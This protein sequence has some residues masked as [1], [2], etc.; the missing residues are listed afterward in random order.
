MVRGRT[1]GSA[2][3]RGLAVHALLARS[4]TRRPVESERHRARPV[5]AHDAPMM[6]LSAR[7]AMCFSAHRPWLTRSSR[8]QQEQVWFSAWFRDLRK[9]A[10]TE[11]PNDGI[12]ELCNARIRPGLILEFLH[13]VNSVVHLRR[14][15]V[16][17]ANDIVGG[18][19][20]RFRHRTQPNG[21]ASCRDTA[22]RGP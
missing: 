17:G 5:R 15:C 9:G 10:T 11:S 20:A 18:N 6:P 2:P 8:K 14:D 12:V 7:T 22:H 16:I 13:S 4:R 19:F 1:T 3:P 21:C